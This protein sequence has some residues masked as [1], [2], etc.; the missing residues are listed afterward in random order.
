MPPFLKMLSEYYIYLGIPLVFVAVVLWVYRPSAKRRYE[1]D[2]KIPF[3]EDA[4][5]DKAGPR[6]R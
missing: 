3:A 5:T 6:G 4:R 2:A 1:A